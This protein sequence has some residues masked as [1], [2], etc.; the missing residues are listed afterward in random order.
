MGYERFNVGLAQKWINMTLKYIFVLGD[1]RVPGYGHLQPFCHV[2]L[3]RFV[4]EEAMKDGFPKLPF[5]WSRLGLGALE[6]VA[7]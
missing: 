4:L 2:P 6:F 1:R 7:L 3:D 5:Q